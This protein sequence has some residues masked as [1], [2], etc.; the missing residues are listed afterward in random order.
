MKKLVLTLIVG[1]GL[2]VGTFAQSMLTIDNLDGTGDATATSLGLFFD[3][4]LA[5]YTGSTIN[6]TVLGGPDAGSLTQILNG[7]MIYSG[8]AG[9]YLDSTFGTYD[10][11]GI[12]AGAAAVLQVQAWV[13][14]AT[15]YGSALTT[16]QFWAYNGTTLV[17]ANTFT[18]DNPTGGGGTPQSPPKSMDG[19]PA[20]VL[21]VPEPATFAL[22]GL[23]ALGLLIFRRRKN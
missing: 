5:P 17:P 7:S 6:V 8:T 10:V 12:S 23:G 15:D 13:G 14:S 4:A 18:F 9:V 21:A 3:G 11:S 16:D 19:M 22:F 20:M 1:A 2:T